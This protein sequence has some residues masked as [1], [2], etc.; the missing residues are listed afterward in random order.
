MKR[1]D[2]FPFKI[3]LAYP[4]S[5]VEGPVTI[6]LASWSI[7]RVG[8]IVKNKAGELVREIR[9]PG[10][11]GKFVTT[12]HPKYSGMAEPDPPETTAVSPASQLRGTGNKH[13]NRVRRQTLEK[14]QRGRKVRRHH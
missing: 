3:T 12:I 10:M 11:T 9:V 5:F 6:S 14:V 7:Q 13:R 2:R 1:D 4:V 8:K